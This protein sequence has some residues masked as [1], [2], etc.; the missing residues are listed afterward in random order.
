[1]ASDQGDEIAKHY[2]DE[3]ELSSKLTE[4]QLAA[5]RRQADEFSKSLANSK[6]RPNGA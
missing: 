2:L 3:I 6:L 5:A 4:E 1:L